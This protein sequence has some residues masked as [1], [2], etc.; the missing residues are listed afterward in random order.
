MQLSTEV[1]GEVAVAHA[2]QEIGEAQ[3]D[4]LKLAF[5]SVPR[6]AIVLDLE[7]T[8]LIDSAGLE[9]LLDLQD[10]LRDRGGELKIATSNHVNRK[11][12]EI[13]RLDRE[14]E[15]FDAVIDAVR[16]FHR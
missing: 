4:A 15:V 1:F 14:F 12:L 7:G 8:E 16:S 11:I 9:L 2:P 13:T 3:I 5:Q 10:A 6:A